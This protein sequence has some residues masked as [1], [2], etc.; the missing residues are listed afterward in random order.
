[1]HSRR[2]LQQQVTVALLVVCDAK[3]F[4]PSNRSDRSR[5]WRSEMR[6]TAASLTT[7]SP[8]LPTAWV[9]LALR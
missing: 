4:L 1:M 5:I 7:L 2:T 8:V 3:G 9:C 6:T